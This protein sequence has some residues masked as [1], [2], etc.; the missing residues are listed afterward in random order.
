M[1]EDPGLA[2]TYARGIASASVPHQNRAKRQINFIITFPPQANLARP[3]LARLSFWQK[4]M[5]VFFGLAA[6][7]G[8]PQTPQRNLI[9][10]HYVSLASSALG[11]QR[12]ERG[13]RVGDEVGMPP[14]IVCP[15]IFML[16]T[17]RINA[18]LATVLSEIAHHRTVLQSQKAVT[19]YFSSKQLLPFGSVHYGSK[20]H[21]Y[22]V[23]SACRS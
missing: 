20:V 4:S 17:N 3:F 11:C 14:K 5:K 10:L 19:A 2:D 21:M 12:G 13:S 9:W 8:S 16:R 22:N 6:A 23:Q 7:D 15:S 1:Q 18:N